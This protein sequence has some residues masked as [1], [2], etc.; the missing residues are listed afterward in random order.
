MFHPLR[1][2]WLALA[3]A[4]LA[5]CTAI[6]APPAHPAA[7]LANLA[8][9]GAGHTVQIDLLGVITIPNSTT[10]FDTPVG[11]LSAISYDSANARYYLLSDDRGNFGPSRIYEASIDMEDGTL[12]AGDLTWTGMVALRNEQGESFAPGEIDPEG[13]VV[14]PDGFWVATEGEA[15]ARPPSAPAILHFNREGA[16][17]KSL[18]LP[19]TF[20]PFSNAELGVRE[21]KGF[22]SLTLSADHRLLI[23]G[24]ENALAQDGPAASWTEGSPSRLLVLDLAR[25]QVVA[26][27]IYMVEKIPSATPPGGDADN[28]LAELIA[29][30]MASNGQGTLLALERSYVAGTGN[31]I[32]LYLINTADASD[33]A[34]LDSLHDQ[35]E[36]VP[37]A[38]SFLLDLGEVGQQVGIA[39]DNIEGM[40]FG[41][42]L[43]DNRLLLLAVSDNNF[44]PSQTTQVWALA[45][46][47]P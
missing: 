19:E 15:A 39:P 34:T 17:V 29:L 26:E 37:V 41:P 31:T 18:M 12:D 6:P 30:E 40:A 43:A 36:F 23:A 4:C 1:L 24:V 46:D 5:D 22:E 9:A 16:W 13:L 45:L 3:L 33:V 14:T 8:I 7:E 11:G 21:N 2:C 42:P 27:H 47:I 10:A 32:R 44:N 35:P 20:L 25:E 38:K 28:G